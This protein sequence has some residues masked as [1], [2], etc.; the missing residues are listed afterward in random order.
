MAV[1]PNRRTIG[2]EIAGHHFDQEA[3]TP[4]EQQIANVLGLVRALML[5]YRLP[6]KSLMGHHELS[7]G[8]PDPGKNF[9]ALIRYL[10]GVLALTDGSETFQELVFGQYF[11]PGA[12]R[13]IAYRRYFDFVRDY[14]VLTNTPAR[15]YRWEGAS[16]YWLLAD[17]L[18]GAARRL[19]TAA[20][21]I[22][23]LSGQATL[24]G[25]V[26][27]RPESHE[28][29][30]L[31]SP[32]KSGAKLAHNVR[33]VAPGECLFADKA[34][35]SHGGQRAVFRHRQPDGAEFLTVY[36]HM[37]GLPELKTGLVYPAGY[38]L[39]LTDG[40]HNAHDPFLHFAMG[41]GAAW[42]TALAHQPDVPL[43]AGYSWV[44][45][46]FMDP[47]A[48]DFKRFQVSDR[49]NQRSILFD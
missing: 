12:S 14:L 6:A 20:D 25:Q 23:P 8:K 26:F 40:G 43:N 48:Y 1:D 49:H 15:L 3:T 11:E 46:H 44:R 29:I 7:L 39:G 31:Y 17:Q 28:G 35:G 42:E 45:Q 33:L 21:Y 27:L 38:D 2:I 5:R 19:P 24:A 47:L 18:P 9:L 30:D 37:A 4:G 16:H 22:T 13:D 34:R 10:V 41:Y 32:V 36:G